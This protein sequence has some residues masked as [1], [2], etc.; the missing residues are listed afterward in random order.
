MLTSKF[1]GWWNPSETLIDPNILA[2]YMP[3]FSSLAQA[4]NAGFW[5]ECMFRAIPLATA[6]LLG[7]KLNREKLFIGSAF[8]LQALIFSAAHANY[9]TQPFYGRLVELMFPS[10]LFATAYLLFGLLPAIISH[11]VYD[12]ILMSLPL[13]I[14]QTPHAW[15]YQGLV[16]FCIT[17]PLWIVMVT[18]LRTGRFAELASTAYNAAWQPT[19]ANREEE[20]ILEI[21]PLLTLQL[22]NL[23]FIVGALGIASCVVWLFT[24]QFNQ[25]GQAL[26]M[27]RATALKKTH[28]I[29][30]QNNIALSPAWQQL[31]RLRST[32]QS[33]STTGIQHSYV[34]QTAPHT[35]YDRYLDSYL[36]PAAWLIRTVTFEGSA[37]ERAEEYQHVF[38]DDGKLV[39]TMHSLP[40]NRPGKQ[41]TEEEARSRALEQI[42]T[43]FGLDKKQMSE[44]SAVS[45]Q[46]PERRDWTFTFA[47]LVT[48]RPE[49]FDQ[50]QL[51]I[52]V[53]IAGDEITDAY[54][55]V[56]VPEA[57]TRT[58]Q[59]IQ[60]MNSIVNSVCRFILFLLLGL[61]FLYA[62]RK[63]KHHMIPHRLF[64][65]MFVAS[66]A[67]YILYYLNALPLLV[68]NFRPVEPFFNQMIMIGIST[69]VMLVLVCGFGS[70]MIALTLTWFTVPTQHSLTRVGLGIS[71]GTLVAST[72]ALFNYIKPSLDPL[73]ASYDALNTYSPL[74]NVMSS[75]LL[76]FVM[77]TT[78]IFATLIVLNTLRRRSL[79]IL[80]G[81]FIGLGIM[82]TSLPSVEYLL[83]WLSS[84]T[85]FGLV[86]FALY[87]Y[88]IRYDYALV[89][90]IV[91]VMI[92]A[93]MLQQAVFNA[94][95]NALTLNIYA[96]CLIAVFA[97]GWYVFMIQASQQQL[98]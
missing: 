56:H 14:T 19:A 61:G 31:T 70:Y 21:E 73:W 57:W 90:L 42:H 43:L 89:P 58:Y 37:S 91:G 98:N 51:R 26:H 35:W 39:R 59:N 84:G 3:W 7:R 75:A 53:I 50:Q 82:T 1:L 65:N 54:R 69:L 83:F 11:F 74:V 46:R 97:Y 67:I 79:P 80:M 30:Q 6:A 29:L 38:I 47:D 63:K 40:E 15:L 86:Y 8:I 85:V 34:W 25:D 66:V 13:F 94:Y 5:E 60:V 62:L 78:G 92:G 16:V 2:S 17:I 20:S 27:N 44:I 24:Q 49:T 93:Q 87:Y 77:Q 23:Q 52:T 48:E 28:H 64:A 95:P 72:T 88:F 4:L 96:T 22:P 45:E 33:P 71:L 32:Y 18:R 9:P 55:F 36:L 76:M 10:C 12:A 81:T 68:A 41:L